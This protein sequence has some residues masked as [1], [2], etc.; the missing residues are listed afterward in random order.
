MGYELFSDYIENEKKRNH[1]SIINGMEFSIAHYT[2]KVTYDAKEMPDRNRDFVPPEII[3]TLR[4]SKDPMIKA[5]FVNK[6]SKMG[7]LFV[8]FADE[9]KKTKRKMK[10]SSS[11]SDED[12]L[13]N[14]SSNKVD[15]QYSQIKK[16]RTCS[17]IF[18]SLCLELL[19]D[20]SIGGSAGG[21][22][23]VRCIRTDLNG[24][25]KGFHSDMVKQQLRAMGVVETA[26]ARQRGY[27]YRIPFNE[28]LRRYKF[29][30]FDFDENVEISKDNCRLLLVRLKMEGW[31]I[32]KSKVFLKYYNEEY[33]AR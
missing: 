8:S 22:H 27:P 6:L 31:A 5:L 15:C 4:Q 32:G 11:S 20:L 19:K 21:T 23:F 28:F 25:P 16:M 1:V 17:S 18:R 29:L 3:E 9:S 7:N 13:K 33:L 14:T 12:N 24:K 30:A 2:G 26:K 10:M